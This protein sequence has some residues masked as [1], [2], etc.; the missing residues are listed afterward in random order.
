MENPLGLDRDDVEDLVGALLE[1]RAQLRNLQWYGEVNRR[2]FVKITKKLDK[3]V[4][5]HSQR[6]YVE[7]K[8]DI[9]PFATNASLI[10]LIAITNEWLA[11]LGDVK[12]HDDSSSS[13]SIKS[14]PRVSV[15]SMINLPHDVLETVERAI[16]SDEASALM[17]VLRESK[18]DG[19]D[20]EGIAQ[21]KLLV[22]LLQRAIS[23]KSRACIVQLLDSIDTLD[24]PDDI[25]QRNV[26]HRF[27]ISLGR[28]KQNVNGMT[29]EKAL[30]E[31]IT[32][33]NY[34][35]PATA[36]N[37]LVASKS[38]QEGRECRQSVQEDG[39]LQLL[40]FI[41]DKM[42]RTE[43]RSALQAKDSLG[44]MPLHYAAQHGYTHITKSIVS[45]M[46][47]W[48]QFEIS[49]GV[50][51]PFW[52]DSD[53][54]S[55]LGLAVLGGHT[56]TTRTLLEAEEWRGPGLGPLSVGK[57]M[58]RSGEV[59]LL[60]VKEDLADI[61]N[62]LVKS[63]V[64]LNFQDAQ[65]ETALHIAARYG[66]EKCAELL[67]AGTSKQ[68]AST[69]ITE[70]TFGWTPLHIACVD[71]HLNIVE[72]LIKSKADLERTDASGWTAKEHAA[73]RGHGKIA[74]EL[75]KHTSATLKSRSA[76][77]SALSSLAES[78]SIPINNIAAKIAQPVKSFGHRYLTNESL[79]LVSLGSMDTRK[80]VDAVNLDRIPLADA[81]STQL[82]TSLSLIVSASGASGEPL[83]VDLP[84]ED[85]IS[86]AP[87]TFTAKDAA[88]V[89]LLF[90]LVPTY[91]GSKDQVVGRAVALLSTIKP[92][93]GSK[94]ISL[95]G[96]ITVPM[97]GAKSLEIIGSVN[98][99]FLVITPFQHPNMAI[100]ENHTYW[101]SMASTTLI[102]HRGLG[103]NVSAR[104][105]L[106][107]GENT[108]QSFI[109]AAN[110]GATYVEFDVQ[111]TK[112]LV[113]VIYHDFLVSETGLDAPVHTMTVEQFLHINNT[114]SRQQSR[115]PSP[116]HE[117]EN[118]ALNPRFGLRKN[119][120]ASLSNVG[121][122]S[123]DDMNERMKHT[124]TFKEKGFKGNSRGNFIQA[125]FTTLEEMFHKLPEST[126]FNIEMKYPMLFESE[127]QEMDTY[128]VELNSFVDAV[129]KM[130]YDLGKKRNIMFSSFNPDICLLLSFKQPSIPILFL[131][132]A[133]T[134]FS[135]DVRATS[136]QEA[137]RF[138][139]RWNLL[140]IVSAA[141]P[142]VLCPRLVKVVKES[143]L[144]C[145][146]YGTLNNDPT[147]VS[148]SVP[149]LIF[150]KKKKKR[151]HC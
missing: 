141:E 113:P 25:N 72:V 75:A 105:S 73:L 45:R 112:D 104:T 118:K 103:K 145:V 78:N 58:G 50:D 128:A 32:D 19:E 151:N 114:R 4:P 39:P 10:N 123:N 17:E 68:Q 49:K 117:P 36:P 55:P 98:F 57:H 15:K 94:R 143:G 70:K 149:S 60:A 126:G 34:I 23:C 111:L 2:G 77:P 100:N 61:V 81:H 40:K 135:G 86:T 59:L 6:G 115:S 38:T 21:Q 99:N 64:N 3:R 11:K 7:S 108:L 30:E 116:E 91:A 8:V 134:S 79:I 41:L 24:E 65:G 90:D 16:R 9:L 1:L 82:D 125:P 47:E 89:K 12:V 43:Q 54:W 120:S 92:S 83:I 119:R 42:K 93:I 146:S 136:L 150:P 87:V 148:V 66:H 62:L 107:L 13:H 46:Q 142:L 33:A 101:K 121:E 124:R 48:G 51:A 31:S 130:V 144:V 85:S 53:G 122:I 127:Q 97:L 102:G 37:S 76:S 147:N 28:S 138:A 5:Q 27:L 35:V 74:R 63:Y 22:N 131:T 106:Q 95:Q 71:G 132:D 52:Q 80:D 44:R 18:Y 20:V 14:L 133:G 140:G 69:E 67:L 139:S 29:L 109:A 129:L 84:V 88:K 137:I 96:D 110:L 26:L 56:E